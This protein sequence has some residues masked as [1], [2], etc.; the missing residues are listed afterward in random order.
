MSTSHALLSRN[1]QSE[2]WNVLPI[3]LNCGRM[4]VSDVGRLF[5][6]LENES[7]EETSLLLNQYLMESKKI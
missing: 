4:S 5:I 6:D 3:K 1:I 7:L 2:N